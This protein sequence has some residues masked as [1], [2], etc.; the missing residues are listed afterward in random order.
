MTALN[1]SNKHDLLNL[2]VE[3]LANRSLCICEDIT[4]FLVKYFKL[5]TQ[6]I[7][8]STE[9]VKLM[10]REIVK[11]QVIQKL[12][13]FIDQ[14]SIEYEMANHQN[15]NRDKKYSPTPEEIIAF[16]ESVGL[17]SQQASDLVYI[18]LNTWMKWETGTGKMSLATWELLQLKVTIES[19]ISETQHRIDESKFPLPS[20]IKALRE[21]KGLTQTQAS[22]LVYALLRQ[23]QRWEGGTNEM[24]IA[25]LE[26][27]RLKA[28]YNTITSESEARKN[29]AE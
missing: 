24:N 1:I 4:T 18:S 9:Q 6:D 25:M 21:T 3:D 11:Q 5:F 17:T 7:I 23:W 19:I 28:E 26:L 13:E 8:D 14:K 27:F 2:L 29:N 12:K 22:K 15:R 20:E 10:S 16:R